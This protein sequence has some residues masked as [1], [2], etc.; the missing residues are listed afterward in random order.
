MLL[1]FVNT[2]KIIAVTDK[3][4]EHKKSVHSYITEQNI[5]IVYTHLVL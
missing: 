2:R 4:S 5:L 3:Y 1:V